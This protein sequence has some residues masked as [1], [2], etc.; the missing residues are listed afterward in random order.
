MYDKTSFTFQLIDHY[1]A[2][3]GIALHTPIELGSMEAIKELVKAGLGISIMAPW[4]AREEIAARSL[5]ALPLG[6]RKLRRQWGILH[7]KSRR[8]TLLDETFVGLCKTVSEGFYT[9]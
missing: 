6:R 4:I 8:L 9:A 2:E 1:F 7:W 5:V 3:A